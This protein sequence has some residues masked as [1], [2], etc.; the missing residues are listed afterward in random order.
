[1][2]IAIALGGGGA[3]GLAH[4]GVLKILSKYGIQAEIISG[5]SIGAFVGAA[6]ACDQLDA[7]ENQFLEVEFKDIPGLLDPTL[8]SQG[9][10]SAKN[11]LEELSTVL[12]VKRIED[13]PRKFAAIAADLILA[14]AVTL[15]SGDLLSAVRASIAV[16]GLFTP[17]VHGDRLLVDGGV[18]EPVPVDAAFK[19]GADYVIAVDL[20]GRTPESRINKLS[21]PRPQL[22]PS[23]DNVLTYVKNLQLKLPLLKSAFDSPETEN[24]HA[25]IFDIFQRTLQVMQYHMAKLRYA[26]SPPHIILRPTVYDIGF[27]DFHRARE[28]IQ[29]GEKEAQTFVEQILKDLEK[30]AA[31]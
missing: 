26:E 10:F 17:M 28:L 31:A 7:L 21:L 24:V 22:P 25:N 13:L 8:S 30:S 15:D 27:L 3:K 18:L 11:A 6:Y 20:Y 2:K 14:E 19:L 16:P 12:T 29:R 4:I 5:T 23:I 9:F 1:M